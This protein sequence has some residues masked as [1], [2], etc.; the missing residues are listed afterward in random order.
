MSSFLK[1]VGLAFVGLVLLIIAAAAIFVVSFDPND[2]KGTLVEAVAEETGRTLDIEG[3]IELSVFPYI[4]FALGRTRLSDAP[5]FGDEPFLSFDAASASVKLVPLFTRNIEVRELR[6]EGFTLKAVTA[7]NGR[8]NWDDLAALGEDDGDSGPGAGAGGDGSADIDSLTIGSIVF[9]DAQL[10]YEDRSQGSSYQISNWNLTS[11]TVRF[12]EPV[13]LETGLDLKA[14]NPDFT[15]RLE[16]RGRLTPG[17]ERTLLADPELTVTLSGATLGTLSSLELTVGAQQLT[18]DASGPVE[19]SSPQIRVQAESESFGEPLDAR[20]TASSL[21]ADLNAE[22]LTLAALQAKAWGVTVDGDLSGKKVMS[23]PSLGGSVKI[24]EFSPKAVAKRAGAPLSPTLDPKALTRM[25][26]AGRLSTTPN[27]VRFDDVV[28]ELDDTTL[29]GYLAVAD[30]ER[31]AV[32]FDLAGDALTLDRYMA[33]ASEVPEAAGSDDDV[34]IPTEDIRAL[35]VDGKLAVDELIFGGLKSTNVKVALKA[36]GGKLRIHPSRADMYGGTYEGDIRIDASGDVPTLSI[37]EQLKG[38]DF[39]ALSADVFDNQQLNGSLDG[40]ITVQGTGA[41]QSAIISTLTGDAVFAF[42]DGAFLGVDI[43]FELQRGLSMIGRG[44]APSGGS[45]GRTEFAELSGTAKV[46]GGVLNNDDLVARLPFMLG[47]GK[48][49][50]DLN[51][52]ALRY[53]LDLQFQKSPELPT[54]ASQFV[55][56]TIPV[57]LGGTLSEPALDLEDMAAALARERVEQEVDKVKGRVLE[58]AGGVL[59]G[60]LGGGKKGSAAEASGGEADAKPAGGAEPPAE[61]AAEEEEDNSLGGR[62]KR[63]RDQI[64]D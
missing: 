4:G 39:G 40:R 22:T 59:G 8:N 64:D 35:D 12:D 34:A 14:T 24:A 36:Q 30:L 18:L 46:T 32:R 44:S 45:T 33:P 7:S 63:L 42:R 53:Q 55:G 57:V 58:E 17:A 11:G 51:N 49:S 2:L 41:T 31:Q 61:E 20:I 23:A 9:K 27:S 26:I 5:G 50:V 3:D 60:L 15:G 16:A 43:P 19:L 21:K 54:E 37:N 6:L 47:S 28:F 56:T 1:F 38:V 25:A 48:G 10:G 29:R 62:L 52:E 13:D